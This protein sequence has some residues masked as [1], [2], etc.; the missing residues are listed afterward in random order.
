MISLIT[1]LFV[2]GILIVVH[3]FGHFI[4]AKRVKV[5][6]EKFSLGFGPAILRRKKNETEYTI[7]AIPLGGYVKLAGDNLQEYKGRPDEYLNKT[8]RERAQIIFCGPLLNYLLGFLVFW[9]IFFAG[10]P[11][12]TAKV[13]SLLDGFGAKEAGIEP[14]DKIISI[15]GRKIDTWDDLQKNI[16]NKQAGSVTKI[17]ILRKTQE[18]ALDVKIKAREDIDPFGQKHSFG[19]IGIRPADEIVQVRHGFIESFFLSIEKTGQLTLMTYKA[20]WRMI[21]GKLSMRQSVTGP[22]GIFYITSKA[23]HLGIIAILNWLALLSISLSIFNLLPLPVL[24]G[25]HLVL[26]FIEKIRGRALSLNTERVITQ[27]GM[28]LIITLAIFVTYNDILN[29]FG[30]KISKFFAR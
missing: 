29:F 20:L 11:M 5:K 17:L 3:E 23:A 1:F 4:A 2:L 7:N 21:T 18:Y 16:Q 15:D 14:G 24:D 30:D 26:L 27:I 25:G 6:V 8:P 13:G 10:Y 9:L 12:L 22:L 19:A 28:T